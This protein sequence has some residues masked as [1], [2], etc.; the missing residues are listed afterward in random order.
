MNHSGSTRLE[1]RGL[2]Y[3]TDPQLF[4]H[5]VG[6]VVFP[7]VSL[8]YVA[9]SRQPHVTMVWGWRCQDGCRPKAKYEATFDAAWRAFVNHHSH[10]PELH[11]SW[12]SKRFRAEIYEKR[13]GT[14]YDWAI[15]EERVQG[16]RSLSPAGREPPNKKQRTDIVHI[17]NVQTVTN[18]EELY[19]ILAEYGTVLST[20][21]IYIPKE[22]KAYAFAKYEEPSQAS[23]AVEGLEGRPVHGRELRVSFA[24]DD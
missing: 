3:F 6:A 16:E 7:F 21:I 4:W 13:D 8:G 22:G 17:S 12:Q 2:A 19:K 14:Y 9:F 5:Q 20:K 15:W 10:D 23:R 18:N 11:P 24:A 1:A